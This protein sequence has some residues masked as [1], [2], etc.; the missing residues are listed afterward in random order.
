LALR[1]KTGIVKYWFNGERGYGFI[2]PHEGG[3]ALF[4]HHSCI[5]PYAKAKSLS[6][7]ALVNYEVTRR[8]LGGLWAKDV[9]RAY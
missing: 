5:S 7:G 6:K 2:H 4:V 8:K 9:C 1:Q 3:G